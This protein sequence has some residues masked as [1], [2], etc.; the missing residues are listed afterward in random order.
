MTP[1]IASVE[2]PTALSECV[3]PCPTRMERGQKRGS[4]ETRNLFRSVPLC[5]HRPLRLGR[6]PPPSPA[7]DGDRVW[8][9]VTCRVSPAASVPLA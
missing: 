5:L 9:S 6:L 2:S 4:T 1:M 8:V 3:T 7:P